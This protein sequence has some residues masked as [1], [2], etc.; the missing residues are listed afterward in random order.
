MNDSFLPIAVLLSGRGRTL[1]NLLRQEADPTWPI[2][3]RLVVACR[4]DAYGLV[5]ARQHGIPARVVPRARFADAAGYGEAVFGACREAGA[6]LVAMAGFVRY[7]PIPDDYW[8]KVTNIHPSLIPAFCGKGYYGDRVH[9]AVLAYGAKVTGCTVH[10]VDNEYDHGPIL[11]QRVVPVH[12]DDTVESL[13]RR[14]FEAECEAYPEALRAIAEDRI[15]I[16]GRRVRIR[17]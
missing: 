2:R 15:E 13:G 11:V 12:D 9:R 3:V 7:V 16:D 8:L 14:V 17:A 10:F 4:P 6:R 5:I 1:E